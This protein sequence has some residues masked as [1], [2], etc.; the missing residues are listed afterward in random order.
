MMMLC[1]VHSQGI[2]LIAV[3]ITD[4]NFIQLL[5]GWLQKTVIGVSQI[6]C[7]LSVIDA[8]LK[9]RYTHSIKWKGCV[10][11]YVDAT[12]WNNIFSIM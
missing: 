11:W 9:Q 1:I 6:I 7:V 5:S 4:S 3:S 8:I 10:L 2:R 12:L